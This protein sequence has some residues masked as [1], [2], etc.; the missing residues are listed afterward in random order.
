MVDYFNKNLNLICTQERD[1]P[2]FQ[3]AETLLHFL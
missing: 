1:V 3:R 2:V